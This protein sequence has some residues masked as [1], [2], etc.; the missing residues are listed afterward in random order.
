MEF[1]ALVTGAD[2]GVGLA[3]VETLLEQGCR[4]FAGRYHLQ[5]SALDELRLAHDSRLT[6]I[7][8]DISS[9]ESVKK[10]AANVLEQTDRLDVLINN[11]GILGDIEAT[12]MEK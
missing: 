12:I 3:L 1:T 6:L 7:P 10:A 8:L 2:H 9:D 4:V 5:E 11:A